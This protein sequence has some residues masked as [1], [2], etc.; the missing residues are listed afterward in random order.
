MDA[1]AGLAFGIIVIDVIRQMGV[2]EDGAVAKEVMQSGILT[3]I[4]M[5]VIYVLTIRMGVQSR[6]L[7]ETSENGGIALAQIAGHYL[8][9]AGSLI[10]AVT[11]TFACLKTSI[12]LVTSCA[13]TFAR[14][15]PDR[16]S[17][18]AW[19]V[20][21]T[22]VSFGISNIGLSSIISYSLPVLMLI[23]PPAIALIVLALCGKR[24][25]HDRVVYVSMLAFT[26]AAALFDFF[27]TLPGSVQSALHLDTA[28]E[29]ARKLL[30]LFDRNLGWVVPAVLGLAIGLLIHKRRAAQA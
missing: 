16:L 14:M 28:V 21:F 7:F 13:E 6:G 4:L 20:L 23:Y 9:S 5:A 17:Y 26:W 2:S 12:G 24:F 29:F 18:R 1:I 10:L 22:V 27:K 3:G 25:D 30:P 15:F 8:G 11:I 19:A